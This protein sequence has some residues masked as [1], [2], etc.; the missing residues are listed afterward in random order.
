MILLNVA[1]IIVGF[2]LLIKG[3]DFFVDGA[4]AVAQKVGVP[5]IVVGLTIVA[6]GTSAPEAAVSIKSALSGSAGIAI[7]NVLGSNIMNVCVILGLTA[8]VVKLSI[9]ADAIK[10]DIPF[11]IVVSILLPILGFSFGEFHWIT[12]CIFWA[13]LIG[14]IVFLIRKAIKTEVEEDEEAK[15]LGPIMILLFLIGGMAAIVIGS[16]L[17]VDGAKAIALSFGVSDRVIGLTIIA[18]GTSLPE[19]M[20]SLTAARKGNADIAVGNIV[21]SNLFNIL[22]ILGT[23]SLI[24]PVPFG[25]EYLID[26]LLAI[27]AVVLLWLFTCKNRVLERKHGIVYLLVYAI[28]L[29]YLLMK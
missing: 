16:S 26:A 6:F 9:D 25:M 11:L 19:L 21:G 2:V 28:Y 4:V 27:G 8:C 22:F 24:H 17:A 3:A 29:A 5:Q 13:L 7:G 1:L 15:N 10:I 12:G 14:Y 18:F 23:T 20:T